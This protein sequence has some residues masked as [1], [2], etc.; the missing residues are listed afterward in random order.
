MA[1]RLSAHGSEPA[2]E[3]ASE[4]GS[5]RGPDPAPI[6]VWDLPTRVFHVLLIVAFAGAYLSGEAERWPLLHVSLGWTVAALVG[7]RLAWGFAGTRHARFADF[8]R[9]PSDV[10]RY[11]ASLWTARPQN[12]TGHNPAGG[13]AVLALLGLCAATAASG[14]AS[15]QPGA[16]HALEELHEG[17]AQA[18]LAVVGVHVAGVLLASRVHHENLVRAMVTGRKHGPAGEA[19]RSAVAWLAVVLAAAVLAFWWAQWSHPE[20]LELQLPQQESREHN[21]G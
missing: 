9:G 2:S 5:G 10:M 3:P 20:W 19:I 8:V 4:R 6:L 7:F 13:W 15:V 14:W 12:H 21:R 16:P 18:L 11:L 17:C 1:E